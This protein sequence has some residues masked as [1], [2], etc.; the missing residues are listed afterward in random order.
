[1]QI[2]GI[3]KKLVM[4]IQN[5]CCLLYVNIVLKEK[6]KYILNFNDTY[7]EVFRREEC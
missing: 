5:L 7:V 3:W 1:M 6:Y 2:Y 4:Y